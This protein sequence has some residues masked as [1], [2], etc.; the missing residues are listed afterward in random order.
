MDFW[1][2]FFFQHWEMNL[3]LRKSFLILWLSTEEAKGS[4][5]FKDLSKMGDRSRE[6]GETKGYIK[7]KDEIEIFFR[8]KKLLDIQATR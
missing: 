8:G 1:G 4:Y 2:I 5:W 6:A 7:Q 3:I